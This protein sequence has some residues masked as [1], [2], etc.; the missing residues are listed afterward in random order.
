M[1]A[2]NLYKKTEQYVTGLFNANIN[3]ALIF[4]NLEH[5]RSVVNRTKEIAGHYFLN[6]KDMLAVYVAAWFHDTGYL[7]TDPELSEIK[8]KSSGEGLT[9]YSTSSKSTCVKNLSVAPVFSVSDINEMYKSA[10]SIQ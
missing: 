5:T 1:E 7:F 4:H 3:P 2:N 9:R 10:I 8:K 6:E